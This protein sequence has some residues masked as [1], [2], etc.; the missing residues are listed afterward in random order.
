[1]NASDD[2]ETSIFKRAVKEAVELQCENV[3]NYVC[4][5]TTDRLME[6]REKYNSLSYDAKRCFAKFVGNDKTNSL[7]FA[8]QCLPTGDVLRTEYILM[9]YLN[10][11]FAERKCE[12]TLL[13]RQAQTQEGAIKDVTMLNPSCFYYPDPIPLGCVEKVEE[14]DEIVGEAAGESFWVGFLVAAVGVGCVALIAI[15][16]VRS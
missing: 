11:G 8:T 6:F 2:L 14:L 4:P 16:V 3:E 13:P 12:T 5:Y 15:V 1:M 9:E 10:K 7:L